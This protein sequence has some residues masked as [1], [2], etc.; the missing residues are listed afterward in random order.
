MKHKNCTN[1]WESQSASACQRRKKTSIAFFY[2]AYCFPYLWFATNI[3]MQY[4]DPI[5]RK[6]I[7]LCND[8]FGEWILDRLILQNQNFR[9]RF[10]RPQLN[11][12]SHFS[13]VIYNY[14]YFSNTTKI[15]LKWHIIRCVVF[16][17]N[18]IRRL[19]FFVYSVL[20]TY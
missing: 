9:I 18:K 19:V 6:C 5:S 16:H 20:Y 3:H 10:L 17:I 8:S 15:L 12:I 4:A 11:K 2:S 14:N 1:V 7:A 13:G